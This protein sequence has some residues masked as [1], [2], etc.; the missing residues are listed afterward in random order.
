MAILRIE[1]PRLGAWK[2]VF[3]SDLLT[4]VTWV[5][6]RILRAVDDTNFITADLTDTP[7]KPRRLEPSAPGAGRGR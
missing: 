5:R 1:T 4:E 6:R 7:M 3:D 2:K